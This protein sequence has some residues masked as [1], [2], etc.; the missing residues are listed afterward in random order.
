MREQRQK[1]RE[2]YT[3]STEY[4]QN[5]TTVSATIPGSY[6]DSHGAPVEAVY[7]KF[8]ELDNVINAPTES[9]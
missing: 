1:E 5:P 6:G 9:N 2:G 7:S 8:A 3:T 4:I